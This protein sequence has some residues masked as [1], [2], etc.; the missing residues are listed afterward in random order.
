MEGDTAQNQAFGIYLRRLP[1]GGRHNTEREFRMSRTSATHIDGEIHCTCGKTLAKHDGIKCRC[2]NTN[3][4]IHFYP[5]NAIGGGSVEQDWREHID[6][7]AK[8]GCEI[9]GIEPS[10]K[11]T[12]PAD[13]KAAAEIHFY[14]GSAIGGGSIATDWERHRR[15]ARLVGCS[16]CGI[17]PEVPFAGKTTDERWAEY[18]ERLDGRSR[19]VCDSGAAETVRSQASGAVLAGSTVSNVIASEVVESASGAPAAAPAPLGSH[20]LARVFTPVPASLNTIGTDY[21][22]PDFGTVDPARLKG[23][24]VLVISADG[25]ELPEIVVP[26][27]YLRSLGAVVDLAGQDWIFQW[28]DPAGHIVLAEWLSDAICVKA[29][30]RLSDVKLSDYDAVFIPGGAWNPDMLRTDEVALRLVREAHAL[31][32]IVCSLCHGPQV[33]ISAAFDAPEGQVNFPAAGVHIT[34]TGSIRRDLKN[35]GF[36]VHDADATVFDANANLLTARDPNDLGPMCVELA[37][38]IEERLA[39]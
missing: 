34:G 13:P 11:R 24:R 35:A 31:G 32:L 7:A 17:E 18:R 16:V 10:W 38:L 26:I 9:C 27:N 28:R 37:K 5:G 33:L 20:S 6:R 21:P 29:D 23:A 3:N 19:F 22:L 25:P 8:V 12:T 1:N 14:P 2:G 39:K 36:I 30:L 15:E 4:T